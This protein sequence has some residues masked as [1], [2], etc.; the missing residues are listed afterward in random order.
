MMILEQHGLIFDAAE[1]PSAGRIAYFTS[2][3][4][5]RSGAM[6]CG[7]QNGPQKHAATSTIRLCRSVDGGRSWTLLP[8]RFATR[9]A[10]VPGS[11]GAAEL[12]EAAAG[13]L[14]LL[15]TWFDRSDPARPLF[16]PVTGGILKSRQLLAVSPDDGDTWTD[17]RTLPTGDLAGCAL[18]GPILRW[19][20]GTI[21]F[22]FESFKEFDDPR[23]ARHAAWLMVSRDSGESFSPPVLVA[24]HAEHSIYYWDQRLCVGSHPGEFTALFWTHDLV[25]KRDLAV[26][27]RHGVLTGETITAAPICATSIPG[28]IAAPVRL[29]DGRLLAF[30]VDRGRPATMTLWCSHDGGATWPAAERLVV[31]THDERAALTQ[32]RENIDFNQ[33]WEDMGKWSFGHPAIRPVAGGRVLLAWYAG[34]PDCMSLHWARVRID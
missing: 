25:A 17:W 24:Q 23:P 1:Q 20:D 30:V 21:A 12:V 22:P 10:D 29:D 33:Y 11:L 6:L 15:A 31:Y 34:T 13:R 32:G 7:F 9:V 28:Q 26:H 19:D 5:L 8:A 18:T 27:L 3:C 2:L 4:P 14:L 16:D